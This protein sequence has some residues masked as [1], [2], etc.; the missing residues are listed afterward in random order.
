MFEA[1]AF[2]HFGI[3]SRAMRSAVG[4]PALAL[5]ERGLLRRHRR[6]NELNFATKSNQQLAWARKRLLGARTKTHNHSMLL[7]VPAGP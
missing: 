1:L 7:E 2:V 3:I 4:R 6:R 5:A